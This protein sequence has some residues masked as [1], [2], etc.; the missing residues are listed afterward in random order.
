VDACYT[1]IGVAERERLG[2]PYAISCR[3]VGPVY[4]TL[5]GDLQPLRPALSGPGI[6]P[7]Q[8]GPVVFLSWTELAWPFRVALV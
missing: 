3:V 8:R 5:L 7:V 2:S 1:E 6:L 4:R